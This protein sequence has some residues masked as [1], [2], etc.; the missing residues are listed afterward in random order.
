MIL[1]FTHRTY[2][3]SAQICLRPDLPD[4]GGALVVDLYVHAEHERRHA[5]LAPGYSQ[6][7]DQVVKTSWSEDQLVQKMRKIIFM[8]IDENYFRFRRLTKWNIGAYFYHLLSIFY[9][10]P[11]IAI[12]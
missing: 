5:F 2:S 9:Q 7:S 8:V 11:C 3:Q 4:V 6:V 12:Q 1:W 10:F